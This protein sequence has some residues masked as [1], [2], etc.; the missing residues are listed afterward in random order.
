MKAFIGILGFLF[1]CLAACATPVAIGLGLYDWVITDHEFKFALWY[2]FKAWL[3]M[4]GTG[5]IVGYPCF[6]IG[7]MK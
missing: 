4:L 1:L 3:W 6:I 7:A 5:L 2:G